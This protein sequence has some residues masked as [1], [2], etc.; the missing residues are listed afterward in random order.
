MKNALFTLPEL[1]AMQAWPLERKIRESQ[2]LIAEWYDH[3]GGKVYAAFSAGKDST[4]LLHLARQVRPDIPGVYV[5]TSVE[6]PENIAFSL[7]VPNVTRLRCNMPFS[8]VVRQFGFPIISKEVSKRIYYA[9]QG[10][11]WAKMQLN[12]FNSDGTPS[13]FNLRF[14]K[15]RFLL[16]APF[17]IAEKCCTALKMKPLER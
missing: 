15:W 9:R 12:G 8:E 3:F 11:N 14:K 5:D 10:S 7:T 6:Y 17:L 2:K 16:D 13:K 1:K 4:L